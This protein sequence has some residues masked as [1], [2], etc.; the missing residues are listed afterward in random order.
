MEGRAGQARRRGTEA[1]TS[2]SGAESR[3]ASGGS[4]A[5]VYDELRRLAPRAGGGNGPRRRSTPRR[6]RASRTSAVGPTLFADSS[7]FFRSALAVQRILIEH[8]RCRK[9]ARLG[10]GRG[11]LHWT[12]MPTPWAPTRAGVGR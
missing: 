4:S 9:A 10:E 12:T 8:A 1:V 6:C 2:A 3:K 11:R 7:G 5:A